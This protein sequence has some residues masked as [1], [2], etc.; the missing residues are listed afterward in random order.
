MDAP[1][2]APRNGASASTSAARRS[3]PARSSSAAE[4]SRSGARHRPGPSAARRRCSPTSRRLAEAIAGRAAARRT[5][6]PSAL[7]IGVPE[8]VDAE[9]QIRS[10]HLLDWSAIPLTERLRADRSDAHR[11]RRA[12]RGA[13]RGQASAPA[14]VRELSPT[15]ASAAGSARPWCRTAFRWWARAA[16][17]WSSRL[18]RWACPAPS[19]ATGPSSSW[20]TTPPV[21]RWRAATRRR[22]TGRVVEGAE[23]VH[24][25][26]ERG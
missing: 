13:G 12:R 23:T 5:R 19:A 4:R 22:P 7:G 15:S 21:R 10:A 8:L 18:A 26:R 25:R 2:S 9:G 3:P 17:H 16:G 1:R 11:R 24:R 6:S 20:K 14:R